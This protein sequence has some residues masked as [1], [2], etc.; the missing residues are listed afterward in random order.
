MQK[1]FL[2]N[3]SDKLILFFTGWGCDENQFT[4][5][6]TK[7]NVLL[8]YD[9][10]NLDL[11]FDFSKY[12]EINALAYS[13]GVFISSIMDKKIPN[14]NKKIAINGN[15]YLFDEKFG[16]S[17]A[18]VQEFKEINLDNYLDFRRKYMVETDEE[19]EK[20]NELQSLRT[21]ESCQ[22]ELEA[23][24]I[25]YKDEKENIN[26]NFDKAIIA[27]DDIIF[28]VENQKMFY[29]DKIKILPK[30]KHHIFFK[31]KT[32]EEILDF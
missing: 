9:Y 3:N 32:F 26:Q 5:L 8:L 31:F 1:Y 24:E 7:N 12:I 2:D 4:N 29:K 21:L 15:P 19:F 23:L 11:E 18:L 17:K 27:E 10:Q 20:Y 22:S 6:T 14:V 28:N 13:A 25:L 30:A 16:L